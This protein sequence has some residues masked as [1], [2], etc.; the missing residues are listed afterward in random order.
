MTALSNKRANLTLLALAIS[1]FAIGS[2]EFI[3]VG[4]IPMLIQD[5][6]ITL[7]QAGLTVSLYAIGIVIGAPLLTLLTGTLNRRTL[8]ILTMTIFILGNIVT[9]FAPT[10]MILLV[11]RF[12]ASL[13]HG[14][15]MSVSSLIAAAVVPEHRRASAIAIMFT[16]LTVATVTG[17][18]LGTFIGQQTSWQWSFIFITIIGLIGLI[19]N[20]FLIPKSLPIP[21]KA[22]PKGL[23]R[24]LKQPAIRSVLLM[25]IFGYGAPFVVYTYLTPLLNTQMGWSMSAIVII[26]V[27]YGIMVAIGNTLGGKWA[28]NDTLTVLIRILIGLVGVMAI[29]WLVQSM[30]WLG[31]VAVLLMGLFA[32]MTV[33][34]L[35]LMV[36]DQAN[37]LVPE[38]MTLAASLNISAF[39]IG[40]A[41]GSTIGG[42]VSSSIGLS[43]TPLFSI[44]MVLIAIG[45]GITLKKHLKDV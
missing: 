11:G 38:D 26:L 33:P 30:H 34:G 1:A 3:S 32:F 36:M 7:S 20:A 4:L 18:P 29:L 23:M 41:S 45:V 8:M 12:I 15:F 16:G 13:A 27:V 40:I 6:N 28:N 24:V 25:T 42:L 39:N 43:A 21:G 17:V 5:F 19:A 35:Q 9:A 14:L 2:T 31:L 44:L 10:F 37:K 22:D